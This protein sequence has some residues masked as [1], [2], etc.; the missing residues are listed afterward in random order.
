MEEKDEYWLVCS[1]GCCGEIDET[2]LS[3]QGNQRQNIQTQTPPPPPSL[4]PHLPSIVLASRSYL[5]RNPIASICNSN[6]NQTPAPST[7][8]PPGTSAHQQPGE[9]E[10]EERLQKEKWAKEKLEGE[11]A[12]E[13]GYYITGRLDR[14]TVRR[15]KE[16]RLV[17]ILYFH[18]NGPRTRWKN[19]NLMLA[20]RLRDLIY[21]TGDLTSWCP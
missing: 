18:N 10:A 8:T 5:T 21:P 2:L 15:G 20:V 12:S 4:S 1:P 6:E 17:F 3:A 19:H 13:E 14:E 9:D 16:K 7:L 11:T